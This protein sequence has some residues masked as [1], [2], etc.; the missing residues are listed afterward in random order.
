MIKLKLSIR[1]G[2][3]ALFVLVST[4]STFTISAL[5]I[6][7]EINRNNRELKKI[8]EIMMNNHKQL[9]KDEVERVISHIEFRLKSSSDLSQNELQDIILNWVATLRFNY[10][11]YVFINNY[12]G[13]ALVFDGEKI[14]G[15]KDVSNM[16]DVD[17]FRVFD[18]EKRLYN[19]ESGGYFKYKFKKKN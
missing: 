15:I 16:T 10:G 9:I 4:L 14:N 2:L 19:S 5:W 7:S 13:N 3:F 1:R 6:Y 12:N 18:E 11:G 17:G 8:E